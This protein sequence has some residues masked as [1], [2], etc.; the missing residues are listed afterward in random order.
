MSTAL[1]NAARAL[2]ANG[3]QHDVGGGDIFLSTCDA[4]EALQRALDGAQADSVEHIP[5]RVLDQLMH[6]S[7]VT[8]YHPAGSQQHMLYGF[9]RK[10]EDEFLA[11]NP[12]PA[13]QPGNPKIADGTERTFNVAVRRGHNKKVYVVS[14]TYANQYDNDMHEREGEPF[15]ANGWYVTGIDMGGEYDSIYEALCGPHDEVAGWQEMPTWS[16]PT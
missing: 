15:I 1:I 2:L 5:E 3:S 9:A 8:V 13:W 6:A 11:R 12:G 14:A 16:E 7:G 10:V 4:S